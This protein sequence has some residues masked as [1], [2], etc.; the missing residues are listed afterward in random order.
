MRRAG[1]T[2]ARH[3]PHRGAM[4][5]KNGSYG[6]PLPP[7]AAPAIS[8]PRATWPCAVAK[9]AS[10]RTGGR[11]GAN[12]GTLDPG[13]ASAWAAGPAPRA[14]LGDDIDGNG[15]RRMSVGTQTG[16]C[17]GLPPGR[18]GRVSRFAR[19]RLPPPNPSGSSMLHGGRRGLNA[20]CSRCAWPG[21][22]GENPPRPAPWHVASEGTSSTECDAVQV[23][24]GRKGELL[25]VSYRREGGRP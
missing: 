8:W 15:S 4:S 9:Q 17:V 12:R 23:S 21:F 3:A 2:K 14:S 7:T 5:R 18:Q 20:S 19:M 10:R 11:G 25:R 6:G 13:H 24:E 1:A 16:A 22:P